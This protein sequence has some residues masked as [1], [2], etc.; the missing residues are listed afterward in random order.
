MTKD[1]MDKLHMIKNN[2]KII[3]NH[4]NGLH[5]TKNI[6]LEDYTNG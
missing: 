4:I 2:Y 5:I 6:N 3:E 1:H